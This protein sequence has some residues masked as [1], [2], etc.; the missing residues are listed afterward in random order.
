[1]HVA[2]AAG[3]SCLVFLSSIAKPPL[4]VP[5]GRGGVVEFKAAVISDLPVDQVER[6]LRNCGVY[7]HA[8]TA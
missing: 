8:A 6:Q 1:M 4:A 3:A 7:A 5:R 2:A